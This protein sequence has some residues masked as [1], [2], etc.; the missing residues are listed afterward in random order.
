[1][2]VLRYGDTRAQL[3]GV[4][5]VLGDGSVVEHLAGLTRDNTGYHLPAL[6]AGSEGTLG[7]VTRARLRLV[8]RAT[9]RTVALLAFDTVRHAIGSISALRAECPS[10]EAVELMLHSGIQLVC[11]AT[12]LRA[13]F[14]VAH[15]AYLLLEAA[16]VVETEDHLAGVVAT[17]GSVRDAAFAV[18]ATRRAALWSYRERHSDAIN[19]LGAPHKLDVAVPLAA[20]AEF[21]DEVQA[22][23]AAGFPTA[24]VWLFGHAADGNIHV[25]VTGVAPDDDQ[26]DDVVLRCAVSHGGSISAEHGI[27]RAKRAWL[28]L[29]RSESELRA[30]RAIKRALDPDGILN[31]GVLF[32]A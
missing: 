3:L 5:A 29:N 26:V 30:F 23:V 20:L 7:I 8:P 14:P 24:Q 11:D 13:P 9:H 12:A 17:L 21:V 18:D 2:R 28:H 4:E 32:P 16:D 27:G 19:R 31:P 22:S 10:V 1:M 25:N 15:G 6:L